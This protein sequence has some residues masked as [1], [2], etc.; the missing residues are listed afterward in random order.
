MSILVQQHNPRSSSM[1]QQRPSHV[2]SKNLSQNE[3]RC[4][5]ALLGNDCVVRLN[6]FVFKFD[7]F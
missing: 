7:R 4:L 2:P 1:S 3:I 5:Y 6:I